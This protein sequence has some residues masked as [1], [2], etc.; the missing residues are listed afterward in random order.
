[1]CNNTSVALSVRKKQV[2]CAER[3]A[4]ITNFRHFSKLVSLINFYLKSCSNNV[5]V[6]DQVSAYPRR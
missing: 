5:S 3:I 2:R 4:T 6:T 1:M